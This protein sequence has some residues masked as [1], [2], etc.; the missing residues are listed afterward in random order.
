MD[1]CIILQYSWLYQPGNRREYVRLG[2]RFHGAVVHLFLFSLRMTVEPGSLNLPWVL[3]ICK[4]DLIKWGIFYFS[5][6]IQPPLQSN[7]LFLREK[8]ETNQKGFFFYVA[9]TSTD[10]FGHVPQTEVYQHYP[11][12]WIEDIIIKIHYCKSTRI[13]LGVWTP[14]G[15]EKKKKKHD[16]L[17]QLGF[18]QM[19]FTRL[20]TLVS[21]TM[22]FITGTTRGKKY[23]L[24]YLLFQK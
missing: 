14:A 13:Y 2:I 12:Y 24:Y 20:L 22:L 23:K 15:K 5:N 1:E 16:V 11:N 21:R 18:V 7:C 6:L 4:G 17:G 8:R 19:M 10:C 3:F 9:G